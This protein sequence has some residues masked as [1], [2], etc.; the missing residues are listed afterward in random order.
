MEEKKKTYESLMFSNFVFNKEQLFV[1]D[2][3][4]KFMVQQV[5]FRNLWDAE[6]FYMKNDLE[7]KS[8]LLGFHY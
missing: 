1:G 3:G 5:S 8:E 6:T 7:V 2:N 4:G